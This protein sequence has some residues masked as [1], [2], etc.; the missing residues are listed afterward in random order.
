MDTLDV[1]VIGGGING[2]GIAADAS[3]RNLKV[4]LYEAKDFASATS[5]ASS[6]LIH[7]GLRYLEHYEFRL[8]AEALRE[9]EVLLAKA[10]HIVTPMRFV[11]PHRPFLRPAWMIRA[12][13]FLYDFLGKRTTLKGSHGVDLND[14]AIMKPEIMN[15]FE[16]SDCWVDDARLVIENIKQAAQ[17]GAE[18]RNYCRVEKAE[19]EGA[20]WK[21]TLFDET[22]QRE[23]IRRCRALINAAGPWVNSVITEQLEAVSPRGIRLIKGSHIVVTKLHNDPRAYILQNDDKR[24]VFVIPYLHDYSMIGTTDVEYRGEPR[25][26]AIEESEKQYLLDVVNAHFVK[27]LDSS[28]IVWSFSGVRPLC[29]D[30][31]DSPQAVTRD[32]TLNLEQ[33]DEQ[34]PL[35]SIFGGKLTTYRKLAETAMQQLKPYFPE[36]GSAWTAGACL[37]GGE[38]FEFSQWDTRLSRMQPWMSVALRRRLLR[39]Y[40]S[41][42]HTLLA[43]VKNKTDMGE[44]IAPEVFSKE[45]EYLIN[46][47]YA[48]TANDVLWR[49]TKLGVILNE[50]QRDA[51]TLHFARLEEERDNSVSNKTAISQ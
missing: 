32:Y 15:G 7:G 9:R 46:H 2:A 1:I 4:G 3:G 26:V 47:E 48:I 37:P 11:L 23:E 40:G 13:L 38:G 39:Q 12:G 19:R 6:K 16:Y 45:M 33:H 30:E 31:S 41:N 42:V 51:V 10:P 36:M 27:Q 28:H 49:R 35:L 22:T 29:D 5:S 17:N 18:V 20:L 24:I 50:A 44:E 34:G 14:S 25:N 8:V 43:E 21:V